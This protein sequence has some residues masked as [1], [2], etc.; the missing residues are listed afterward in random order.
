MQVRKFVTYDSSSSTSTNP[1][2]RLEAP[3]TALPLPNDRPASPESPPE[4][5]TTSARRGEMHLGLVAGVVHLGGIVMNNHDVASTSNIM[6]STVE[7]ALNYPRQSTEVSQGDLPCEIRIP[8]Y[9]HD[10]LFKAR[11]PSPFVRR[12]AKISSIEIC[13]LWV[14]CNH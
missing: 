4:R 13:C 7:V 1:P 5:A 2:T 12:Y 10:K 11:R 3:V 14:T 6:T 9:E 8:E